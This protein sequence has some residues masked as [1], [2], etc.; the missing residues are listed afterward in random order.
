MNGTS[1]TNGSGEAAAEFEKIRH[2][3]A[4]LREDLAELVKTLTS[5]AGDE[6][7]E[8]LRRLYAS[9]SDKGR[10]TAKTITREVEERPLTTLL[11]AFGVGF[12]GGSL[13]R[14]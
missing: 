13:L 9:L 3:L 10:R 6:M 7:P 4:S 8:E 12:I 1:K 11:L 5:E 2:D 14:R